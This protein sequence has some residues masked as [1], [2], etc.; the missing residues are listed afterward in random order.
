MMKALILKGKN[1]P[2][3]LGTTD[4]PEPKTEMVLVKIT[5]AALNHRDVWIQKGLYA[6]LKF[7][8]IL[9][10]DGSGVVED[11]GDNVD[12]ELI[13]K[14]VIINPS[15]GWGDDENVQ[16]KNYKILG[17]PDDGTFAEY[18]VVPK[19][20]VAPKPPHLNFYEAAALPLAGLTAWRALFTRA[21]CKKG[22]KVLITGIGGGVALFAM[23][24]ALA[25]QA[26]VFVTSSSDKKIEKAIHLGASGG[27][28]YT[29]ENW[30][31]N[32]LEQHGMFDIIIDS[33]AG[34]DFSK[35]IDLAKPGG[36]I[37]CFG[38]TAGNIIDL[39]PQKIFWK[40]L[41]IL[42]STMGS[43]KDFNNMLSF[44]NQ[45]LIRPIIDIVFPL[46]RGQHAMDRM[47]NK[48][49]FGKIVL[50]VHQ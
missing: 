27:V 5:A 15:I 21:E 45:H 36:K 37:V 30:D 34:K 26:S 2:L 13:G 16:S 24:F 35:L 46:E 41:S 12:R 25:A 28:N 3:E 4:K 23:Q 7:P 49:Q 1:Q 29:K 18:V 50:Q 6:G 31:K 39:S 44:V 42:G 47:S 17:L 32:L 10:S 14:E 43:P 9:G 40:Q 22:D 20:N 11:T 8:I 48:E 38:G 19:Q 33:A